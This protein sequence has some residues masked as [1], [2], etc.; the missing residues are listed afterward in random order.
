MERGGSESNMFINTAKIEVKNRL[1]LVN[2]KVSLRAQYYFV[3]KYFTK[4][5]EILYHQCYLW[6]KRWH[7]MYKQGD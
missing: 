3:F 4:Y 7:C 5:L 2:F 6:H 1:D